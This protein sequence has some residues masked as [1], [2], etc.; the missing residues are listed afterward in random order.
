MQTQIDLLRRMLTH[1]LQHDLDQN[2]QM[3]SEYLGPEIVQRWH[4]GRGS[5]IQSLKHDQDLDSAATVLHDL[6]RYKAILTAN[7]SYGKK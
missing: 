7:Q 4:G 1:D 6:P 2:R 3:I 5:I